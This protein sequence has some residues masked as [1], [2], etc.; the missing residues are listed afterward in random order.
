MCDND[1]FAKKIIS[2]NDHRILHIRGTSSLN[3]ISYGIV[4]QPQK[5][6]AKLVRTT[7]EYSKDSITNFA[8]VYSSVYK[9]WLVIDGIGLAVIFVCVVLEG[10]Q[11]W[12]DIYGDQLNGNEEAMIFWISGIIFALFGLLLLLINAASLE[13]LPNFENFG[14][15]VLSMAATLQVK[16]TSEEMILPSISLILDEIRVSDCFGLFLLSLVACGKYHLHQIQH[17]NIDETQSYPFRR[18]SSVEYTSINAETAESPTPLT[19]R[20]GD[21]IVH[22][23]SDHH[24]ADI[25]RGFV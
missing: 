2:S 24:R 22:H 1:D 13:S 7:K 18:L 23:R 25:D 10:F 17:E 14:F 16:F 6:I 19:R 5:N 21:A 15:I 4:L 20:R 11:E 3:I 9:F 8:N 12:D